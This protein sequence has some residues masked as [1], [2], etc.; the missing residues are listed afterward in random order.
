MNV[1]DVLLYCVRVDDDIFHIN[2]T[3]FPLEFCED[4]IE[5]AVISGWCFRLAKGRSNVL[6]RGGVPNEWSFMTILR[7]N[8][9]LPIS[10]VDF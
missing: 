9:N 7:F 5:R 1:V 8:R 4:D 3:S 10:I 2:K 6:I